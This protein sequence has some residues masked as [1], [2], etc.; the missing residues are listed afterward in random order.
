MDEKRAKAL[1]VM[2]SSDGTLVDAP[3][4]GLLKSAGCEV[5]YPA[6]LD[7]AC[8]HKDPEL[9][10]EELQGVS[11]VLA[12]GETYSASLI[13]GLPDLPVIARVGVGFDRVDIGA[14]TECG[15]VVTIT[16]TA[17]HEAVAEHTI[18]LMLAFAKSLVLSDRKI[19]EG[20]WPGGSRTPIREKTLGI[21]GLGRIGR[22]TAVRARA[23]RMN[24]IATELYPDRD[25]VEQNG[26]E[27]VDLDT[28]LARS[29]Y[30]SVHCPLSDETR[31]LFDRDK[32]ARMK[33]GSVFINTA[34]GGL[35]VEKDLIAALESGHLGG[36]GLDVFQSEPTEPN[37]PL[38]G[39]DNVVLSPHRA[40][41]D[42]LAMEN[43][44]LEAAQNVID[45]SQG[46]WPAAAVVN[47]ELEG[48][49]DW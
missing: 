7:F 19:R 20:L 31:G 27:L 43:M 49:W 45:L 46:K 42:E 14:A 30:L 25:F 5:R 41:D 33:K 47:K 16:P 29:D 26:I 2:V 40:G 22:S 1:I 15:V 11:A 17:N 44:G 21:V 12:W 36:A 4:V 3:C 35:V 28:L 48:R 32:F 9:S 38:F 18:A 39:M 37:N 8:G 34:R 23:M 10:I 6:N 24:V 13:N